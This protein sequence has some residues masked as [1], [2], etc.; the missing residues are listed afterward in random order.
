MSGE[1]QGL[2]S[3]WFRIWAIRILGLLAV[4]FIVVFYPMVW[5]ILVFVVGYLLLF[6]LGHVLLQREA[7]K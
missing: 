5:L 2:N 4:P 7:K 6:G 3:W 1:H